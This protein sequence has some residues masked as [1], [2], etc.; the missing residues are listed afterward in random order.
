[1]GSAVNDTTR[2]LGGAL[3]VA[4]LGSVFSSIYG[5]RVTDAISGFPVPAEQATAIRDQ[6]GAAVAG[7]ERISAARR[8]ERWRT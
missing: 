5:P 4:V 3:G 8:G 7:R 6:I 2:Q 1:M